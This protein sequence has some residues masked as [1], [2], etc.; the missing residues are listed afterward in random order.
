M[1]SS[2]YNTTNPAS[3]R[4]VFC[5]SL[6]LNLYNRSWWKALLSIPRGH[7]CLVQ[8]HL[9][10]IMVT[11]FGSYFWTMQAN[12]NRLGYVNGITNLGFSPFLSIFI[13]L[14]ATLCPF[15]YRRFL[16]HFLFRF[17]L[18]D[19]I[20]LNLP[21]AVEYLYLGGGIECEISDSTPSPD[22]M[23]CSCWL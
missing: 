23:T 14:S 11:S 19:V 15:C 18:Y 13:E 17:P 10:S 5:P 22:H 7:Y 12:R 9:L 8:H 2:L 1:L 6:T 4:Q 16:L 21:T 20:P 3:V